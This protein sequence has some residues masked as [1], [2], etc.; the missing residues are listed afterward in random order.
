MDHE[1]SEDRDQEVRNEPLYVSVNAGFSD[2]VKRLYF[3][4]YGLVILKNSWLTEFLVL[5][6]STGDRFPIMTRFL[7]YSIRLG[8]LF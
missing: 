1:I 8:L 2:L 3:I 4:R 6:R 5:I 7:S